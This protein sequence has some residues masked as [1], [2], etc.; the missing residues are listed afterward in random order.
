MIQI[1]KLFFNY[2]LVLYIQ[3]QDV[4]SGGFYSFIESKVPISGIVHTIPGVTRRVCVLKCRISEHCKY[5]AMD[6]RGENCLH[7]NKLNTSGNDDTATVQL[8]EEIS[9]NLKVPGI[10]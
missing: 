8:L 3:F 5:P 4:S 6:A 9:T 10:I 1:M 7:L 2:V